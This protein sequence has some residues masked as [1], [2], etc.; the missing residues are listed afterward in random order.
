LPTD[1]SISDSDPVKQQQAVDTLIRVMEHAAP[2]LPIT[3]TLQ[4]SY[5][6]N[7]DDKDKISRWQNLVHQ[8]TKHLL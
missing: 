7:L 2:L 1:I 4:V 8:M 6:D 5:D 3:Y